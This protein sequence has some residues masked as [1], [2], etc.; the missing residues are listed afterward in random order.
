MEIQSN[1]GGSPYKGKGSEEKEA[2]QR[3]QQ[4]AQ[5][6]QATGFKNRFRILGPENILNGP[7]NETFQKDGGLD[8][9]LQIT[10]NG[11]KSNNSAF[12]EVEKRFHT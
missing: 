1:E 9:D 12:K 7:M 8:D 6:T 5:E 3:F 11:F 10:K 2:Q 4:L